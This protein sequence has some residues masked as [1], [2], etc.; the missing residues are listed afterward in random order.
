MRFFRLP[1]ALVAPLLVLSITA[2][3]PGDTEGHE[4]SDP[5][6][7]SL[8][9]YIDSFESTV[10][11]RHSEGGCSYVRTYQAIGDGQGCSRGELDVG[12]ADA[13]GNL[14]AGGF[15]LCG[16]M[17]I[18]TDYDEACHDADETTTE[19]VTEVGFIELSAMDADAPMTMRWRWADGVVL[20]AEI[21]SARELEAGGEVALRFVDVAETSGGAQREVSVDAEILLV[22]DPEETG[23]C[24]VAPGR[25]SGETLRCG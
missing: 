5:D 14:V 3:D 11:D 22:A 6:E 9:L 4:S 1:R 12:L 16:T 25:P 21:E 8:H 10:V 2:C 19:S 20:E 15:A 18:T 23:G 24:G 7:R 17:T 13:D